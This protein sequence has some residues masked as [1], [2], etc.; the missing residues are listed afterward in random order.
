MVGGKTLLPQQRGNEQWPEPSGMLQHLD[1]GP[2]LEQDRGP[3]D[4]R[5]LPR[6]RQARP[7]IRPAVLPHSS[8]DRRSDPAGHVVTFP[9]FE[10][11]PLAPVKDLRGAR[12]DSI[13]LGKF[14]S[15]KIVL[16]IIPNIGFNGTRSSPLPFPAF[17]PRR[18]TAPPRPVRAKNRRS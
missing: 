8:R 1:V 5:Q 16:S 11:A 15:Q 2:G 17:L 18:A 7:A 6:C 13:D 14:L 10:Q 9:L 4:D 3:Q 12:Q